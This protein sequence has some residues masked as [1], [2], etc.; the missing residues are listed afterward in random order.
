M[1]E[2]QSWLTSIKS[3]Y[4]PQLHPDYDILIS[5]VNQAP[6]AIFESID[7]ELHSEALAYWI[8]ACRRLSFYYL[9]NGDLD[10][11]YSYLQFSYARLQE[12]AC[13][14]TLSSEMKRWCLKRLDRMVLTMMEFCQ[15]QPGKQWQ[16]ET[17]RLIE[18]H[19]CF[20]EGQNNLNLAYPS[21][22]G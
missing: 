10:K 21:G 1:N 3:W 17:T 7:T 6:R 12:M 15:R 9:D 19:V 2:I 13:K 11:S 22:S 16:Q 14:P 20:M 4:Q 5:G 18:L 8:D